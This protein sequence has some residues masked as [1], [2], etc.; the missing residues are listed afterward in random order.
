MTRDGRLEEAEKNSDNFQHKELRPKVSGKRMDG[1]EHLKGFVTSDAK[2]KGKENGKDESS[3][4]K[5]RIEKPCD[6]DMGQL[7][8]VQIQ[9][10]STDFISFEMKSSIEKPK[11]DTQ[12][13]ARKTWKRIKPSCELANRAQENLETFISV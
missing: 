3:L 9:G 7:V 10:P 8:E 6:M 5:T 13:E 12:L 11:I 4:V 1:E 2:M